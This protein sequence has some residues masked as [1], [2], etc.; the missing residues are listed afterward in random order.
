MEPQ[1][2][3]EIAEMLSEVLSGLR[4]IVMLG[5]AA[6]EFDCESPSYRFACVVDPLAD[7]LETAYCALNEVCTD[8]RDGA[9]T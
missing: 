2:L 8:A 7:R 9:E 5:G 6:G 4:G 3:Q 1:S